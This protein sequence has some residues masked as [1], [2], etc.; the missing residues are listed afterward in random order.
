MTTFDERERAF[1]NKFKTD[2]ELRFKVSAR[3]DRLLGLWAAQQMGK[4]G[5]DADAYA[6]DLVSIDVEKAGDDE[7]VDKV[8]ND[9]RAAGMPVADHTVRARMHEFFE[10]ARKQVMSEVR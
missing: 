1:E 10:T 3:R 5:A 8:G 9:L 6:S 4:S 2:E 7:V